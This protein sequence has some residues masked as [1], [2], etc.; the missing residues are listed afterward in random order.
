MQPE[1]QRDFLSAYSKDFLTQ[2]FN[3]DQDAL[4]R[5]GMDLQAQAPS[6]L[7]GLPARVASLAPA[8][9]RLRLLLPGSAAEM[10]TNLAGGSVTAEGVT[11]FYCEEGY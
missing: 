2:I 5:L 3:E 1:A 9:D 6:K 4:S 7:Y 11:T 8:D 10:E